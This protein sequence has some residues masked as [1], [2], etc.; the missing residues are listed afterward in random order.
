[1]Q[2]ANLDVLIDELSHNEPLIQGFDYSKG[3]QTVG[4][5]PP[6]IE[7][8][9]HDE[10]FPLQREIS[11]RDI[12]YD[13]NHIIS[14]TKLIRDQNGPVFECRFCGEHLEYLKSSIYVDSEENEI[15]KGRAHIDLILDLIYRDIELIELYCGLDPDS[16]WL[17]EAKYEYPT[18]GVLCDTCAIQW[19]D[20]EFENWYTDIQKIVDLGNRYRY[21]Q[22]AFTKH[23]HLQILNTEESDRIY[24]K[25]FDYYRSIG[26]QD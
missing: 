26:E 12:D 8:A 5:T 19:Q 6:T 10:D 9:R 24:E 14:L 15:F 4:E 23:Y 22:K 2:R 21:L 18:P 13:D 20:I 7:L 3:V 17:H 16:L 25:R 1:M 11:A